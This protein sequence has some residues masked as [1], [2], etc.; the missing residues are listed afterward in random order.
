M[1]AAYSVVFRS[2]HDRDMRDG[3]ITSQ[4]RWLK[5]RA[6]LFAE[7][8]DT[9]NARK[10]G[11]SNDGLSVDPINLLR[12][13][14]DRG[15]WLANSN[16]SDGGFAVI[17]K[18]RGQKALQAKATGGQWQGFQ[19]DCFLAPEHFGDGAYGCFGARYLQNGNRVCGNL[20]DWASAHETSYKIIAQNNSGS[21][22][23][24]ASCHI[25][26]A[27]ETCPKLAKGLDDLDSLPTGPVAKLDP[28]GEDDAGFGDGWLDECLR[29]RNL[30]P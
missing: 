17:A 26:Y 15:R 10:E 5:A 18:M 21:L 29:S 28:E 22:Q 14:R 27:G 9:A 19:T 16:N 12:V 25:G 8:P 20:T 11:G 4:R 13:T 3:L 23:V 7:T 2:T 6:A 24:L 1:S 30:P